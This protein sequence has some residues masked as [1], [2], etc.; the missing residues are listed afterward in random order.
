MVSILVVGV[1][2]LLLLMSR[3]MFGQSVL[4]NYATQETCSPTYLDMHYAC[5]DLTKRI[6]TTVPIV[7]RTVVGLV[8][9]GVVPAAILSYLLYDI[10]MVV[11]N[12]NMDVE[13]VCTEKFPMVSNELPILI[14]DG[15]CE[16]GVTISHVKEYYEKLGCKVYTAVLY[17]KDNAS[18]C[19]DFYWKKISGEFNF[20]TF[21]FETDHGNQ[22]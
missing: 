14:V 20:V 12:C 8:K 3:A 4:N 21:P 22:E 19:P 6:R 16:T 5:A 17:Y 7:P 15:V 11:V 13:P 9:N 2:V 10:P 18:F 1:I